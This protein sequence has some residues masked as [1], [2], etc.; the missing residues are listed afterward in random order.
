M[1]QDKLNV[2]WVVVKVESGIP[3]F[4]EVFSNQTAAQRRE[5][6]LRAK[7]HPE[8]DEVGVFSSQI[9]P[10]RRKTLNLID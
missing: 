5:N 7:M 9:I 8:N 2:V 1:K 4:A 6:Q 10:N 3:V